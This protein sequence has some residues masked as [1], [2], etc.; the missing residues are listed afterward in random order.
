MFKVEKDFE[1][2]GHRCV[3]IFTDM[4]HRCGYVSVNENSPL[5][6]KDYSD[7]LD[8]KKSELE[9]KEIGKTGIIPLIMSACDEDERI[10]IDSYFDVHGGITYS[11][12]GIGSKYPVESDLYW[13]G[14][15]CA[16]CYDS[17]DCEKLREYFPNERFTES[18]IAMALNFE[19]NEIRT[20]EYVEQEC[21]NLADQIENV[22]NIL[23]Q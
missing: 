4:G 5:W 20:L 12:G 19:D 6:C 3:V 18:R 8:I 22:E 2:Q 11:G 14:F 9:G 16:H 10:Q 1:Y 23:R 17:M 15:D 21:R 7:Y 13:F